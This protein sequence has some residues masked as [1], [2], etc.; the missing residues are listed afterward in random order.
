[1]QLLGLAFLGW[2]GPIITILDLDAAVRPHEAKTVVHA[3]ADD[4]T[5]R[6]TGNMRLLDALIRASHPSA[7]TH[8]TQTNRTLAHW[9]LRWNWHTPTFQLRLR[10]FTYIRL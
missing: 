8:W 3:A 10:C 5:F 9:W 7:Q 4:V 1:M 2:P 6:H